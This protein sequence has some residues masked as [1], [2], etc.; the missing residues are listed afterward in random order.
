MAVE[1]T[2]VLKKEYPSEINRTKLQ[3]I[4]E[5]AD[6]PN[7]REVQ[8]FS[9]V[10]EELAQDKFFY[11]NHFLPDLKE[12]FPNHPHMWHVDRYFPYAVKGPLYIDHV[13]KVEQQ[14]TKQF[15]EAMAL[16]DA[17]KKFLKEKKRRYLCF[18]D[19][20]DLLSAKEELA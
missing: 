10:F 9:N 14:E 6:V 5:Q 1:K 2:R 20:M 16:F 18:K 8:K 11:K 17:K 7:L 13:L 3:E 15:A 19:G 4:K 12:A